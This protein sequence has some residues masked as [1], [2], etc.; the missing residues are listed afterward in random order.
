MA[1]LH[2]FRAS[3][4]KSAMRTTALA[5]AVLASAA[6]AAAG[7]TA[8]EAASV[9]APQQSVSANAGAAAGALT[10]DSV[11]GF[12]FLPQL[13]RL[14]VCRQC[15]SVSG[16][17]SGADM[18]AQH[19]MAFADVWRGVGVFAGQ[20]WHCAVTHWST[21]PPGEGS[22]EPLYTCAEQP[23]GQE[24]PGCVGMPGFA[25]CD[26]CPAGLTTG[27]DHC[28][29]PAEPAGPGY[30]NITDLSTRLAERAGN[31]SVAPLEDMAPLQVYLYRGTNDSTYLDGA[32]NKT[33]A[34]FAAFSANATCQIV[35]EASIPSGHCMPTIDPWLSPASC[36]VSAPWAP[37]AMENCGYDGAGAALQHI[38]GGGLVPPVTAS[39]NASNVYAFNQSLYFGD[40][41]RWPAL[42]STAFAY[43]PPACLAGAACLLHV[44]LHGCG[45]SYLSPSM[46]TSFVLHAG[47]GPWADANNIAVLFPQSGGFI[48]RNETAPA[49]QLAAGC[50]D[51]YGQTAWDYDLRSGPQM[52]ALRNMVAAVAGF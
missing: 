17:S 10:D 40:D 41:G 26:G 2:K 13:P 3:L 21:P 16:I 5:V 45:M 22:G 25:A 39:P 31:G 43:L 44:A 28:K 1:P 47:F 30:V 33:Q 36:G 38:Y 46:N 29:K 14:S 19:A 48:E 52:A 49:A 12:P 15:A 37:P 35:F 18:A 42:A 20:P 32:V 8:G 9:A 24:G 4:A 6:T 50:F 7:S 11:F 34:L 51:S 23:V 27:Y